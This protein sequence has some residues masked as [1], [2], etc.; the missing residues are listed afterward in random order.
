MRVRLVPQKKN[1]AWRNDLKNLDNKRFE[2]KL[3]EKDL[4]IVSTKILS[5]NWNKINFKKI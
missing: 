2:G 4:K 5:K 3:L 1:T